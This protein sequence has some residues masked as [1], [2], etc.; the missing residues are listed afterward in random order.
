MGKEVYIPKINQLAR[1]VFEKVI[2]STP[3]FRSEIVNPDRLEGPR[4]ILRKDMGLCIV[5]NHF[6]RKETSQMFQIPFRD[7][8][9]RKREIVAPV[10][11]HQKLFF[12]DPLSHLLA[13]NLRYIVIEETIR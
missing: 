7:P 4:E 13:V 12:M 8:E 5:A 3:F 11:A 10:A 2:A 9:L 1:D 6:S